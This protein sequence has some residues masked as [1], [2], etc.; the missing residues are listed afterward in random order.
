MIPGVIPPDPCFC[1]NMEDDVAP[2]CCS[3]Q[4]S[5]VGDISAD[6]RDTEFVKSRMPVPGVADD[7]VAPL[8]E[9]CYDCAPQESATTGHERLHLILP[10]AQTESFSRKI[11]A[12]C[13]ISTGNAGWKRISP[14]TAV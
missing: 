1:R 2:L 11:F 5:S 8:E 13:R 3:S 4:S 12:L 14:I 7:L 9:H 10:S 6:L